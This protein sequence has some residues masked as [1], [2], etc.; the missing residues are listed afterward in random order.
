V[1]VQN[2]NEAAEYMLKRVK[3]NIK[4]RGLDLVRYK[5]VDQNFGRH[6][7]LILYVKRRGRDW[8]N[9]WSFNVYV[10]YQRRWFESFPKYFG[11]QDA[12]ASMNLSVLK[13]V[14]N[15]P[16]SAVAW[17]APDGTVYWHRNPREALN[18]VLKNKWYR[19]TDKTGEVV[20]YIPL[21]MLEKMDGG[22]AGGEG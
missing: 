11:V 16:I 4:S 10:I 22:E 1:Y 9:I 15:R 21:S 7:L 18:M 2:V 17:V 19:P 8:K 14:A 3:R 13:S 12:A 5:V 20:A 6:K